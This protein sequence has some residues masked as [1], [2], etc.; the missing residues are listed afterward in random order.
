MKMESIGFANH[1]KHFTSNFNGTC[2]NIQNK[3]MG[4]GLENTCAKP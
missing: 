2:T 3:S 1:P 4:F